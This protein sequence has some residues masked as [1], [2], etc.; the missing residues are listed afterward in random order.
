[1]AKHT[2]ELD[3]AR[4]PVVRRI[5]EEYLSGL[6]GTREIRDLLNSDP[7]RFPPRDAP[8]PTKASG[9]WS[10]SSIWEV[11]HNP[12]YTG[13]QVW[14][15]RRR[16]KD[17]G[18]NP[19]SEWIWSVEPSHPAVVS[20]GEWRAV[21]T[22][23][24]ANVR[25]RRTPLEPTAVPAT[26]RTEYLFRGLVRC[27]CCGLRMWDGRPASRYYRCQPSH[28]RSTRIP[29]DHPPIAH[30]GERPLLE[31]VTD[32]LTIAV[33]GSERLDYWR[34]ALA[35]SAVPRPSSAARDRFAEVEAEIAD[36]ERRIERQIVALE[37]DGS[38]PGLRR[39]VAERLGQLEAAAQVR[40]AALTRLRSDAEADGPSL[41]DIEAVLA[42]DA[43]VERRTPVPASA[44]A[45]DALRQP[46]PGHHLPPQ[47]PQGRNRGHA[48]AGPRARSFRRRERSAGTRTPI[49]TADR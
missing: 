33:F 32:W 45:A 10:T 16:K 44:R 17:N 34:E 11:L 25:V 37:D 9:H 46:E 23:A 14:N 12:K 13:Y 41:D 48:L 2:L 18:T 43:H 40:R 4:A 20:M 35:A 22:R 5:Y 28:Q 38:T 39:R 36:I 3:P 42:R 31:A 15:R 47:D 21:Q 19:E 6:R 7:E 30:V 26:G 49:V 24:A 27:G 29:V 1:M 8:D